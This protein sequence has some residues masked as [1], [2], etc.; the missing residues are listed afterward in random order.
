V[1]SVEFVRAALRFG[2]VE[3]LDREDKLR[4]LRDCGVWLDV[5]GGVWSAKVDRCGI[6]SPHE[7]DVIEVA[8]AMLK[9]RP[10]LWPPSISP[11]PAT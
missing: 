2:Q 9:M 4:L 5:E 11:D 1:S 10:E 6:A 8:L 3:E 7:D